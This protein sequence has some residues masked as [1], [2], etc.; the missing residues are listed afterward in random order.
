MTDIRGSGDA[1]EPAL[2]IRVGQIATRVAAAE[3]L[4]RR[5]DGDA[6]ALSASATLRLI[7]RDFPGREL[8]SLDLIAEDRAYRGI[9]LSEVSA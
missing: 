1:H 3:A 7:A 8:P 9:G 5:G 4:G 2:L 6:A